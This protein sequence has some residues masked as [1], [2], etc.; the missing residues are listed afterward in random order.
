MKP[1]DDPD[2][3]WLRLPGTRESFTEFHRF[4]LEQASAASLPEEVRTRV[5]LV[6]E[7][8]L[9]NVIDYACSGAQT[10]AIAVGCAVI[11]GKGFLVRVTDPG[12]PFNP[13]EQQAPELEPSIEERK[14]GGLGILLARNMSSDMV[15]R[16]RQDR[17]IL[18][19]YF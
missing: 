15:Y 11:P 5:D 9:I 1:W 12:P 4:V 8:V 19:I 14:I 16:R 6:L 2:L 17:N 10:Q 13:L 18:D 3:H 7:E